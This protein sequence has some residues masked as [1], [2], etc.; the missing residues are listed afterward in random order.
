M[1]KQK[2]LSGQLLQPIDSDEECARCG[3]SENLETHHLQY[4]PEEVTTLCGDCHTR[5]HN[6]STSPF[7]PRQDA[8]DLFEKPPA[9]SGV[10]QSATVTVKQ[11]NGHPYFYWNWREED[12]VTSA[13]ICRLDN[14]PEHELYDG[15]DVSS[16]DDQDGWS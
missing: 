2:T 8:N 7:A 10:P 4:I 13:F 6:H 16:G 15:P 1:N 11:V 14:A 9:D 12:G 5:V 3:R